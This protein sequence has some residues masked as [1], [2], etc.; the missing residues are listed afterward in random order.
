MR[1]VLIVA[2]FA[3]TPVV[4]REAPEW[5]YCDFGVDPK[6]GLMASKRWAENGMERGIAGSLYSGNRFAWLP[7]PKLAP[8]AACEAALASPDLAGN[9]MRRVSLLQARAAHHV[10]AG[11]AKAALADLDAAEAALPATL[12]PRERARS[13]TLSLA[14]LRA[15]ALIKAGDNPAAVRAV[16]QAADARPWSGHVQTLAARILSVT[17]GSEAASLRIAERRL[18]LDAGRREDLA[19]ARQAGGQF[20]AALADWRQVKPPVT[21]PTTVVVPMRGVFM[22]GQPGFPITMIDPARVGTAAL[23]AA[24]AGDAATARAW[25]ADARAAAEAAT[26]P[27]ALVLP[28]GLTGPGFPTIDKPAQ[29]AEFARYATLVDAAILYQAGKTTEARA[30]LATFGAPS[31]SPAGAQAVQRITGQTIAAAE[32]GASVDARLLFAMLP[33][34]EGADAVAVAASDDPLR[35]FL[36]GGRPNQRKPGR[37]G[38][39]GGGNF[40]KASGFKSKPMKDGRGTTITFTGDASSNYAVEEMALLRAAE[41]AREAGRTGFVI[42]DK[43]DYTRTVTM[44][45]GGSAIGGAQPAGYQTELDVAFADT[46]SDGRLVAAQSVLAALGAFYNRAP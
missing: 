36:I 44:T 5:T 16:E 45:Y 22:N 2:L 46:D 35:G 6:A 26:P 11:D 37:N 1:H 3:V 24:F 30:A 21:G 10:S 27:P 7:E 40:F 42:L 41:L 12:E 23:A 17:P 31:A 4:A 25:L 8:L 38:Y 34:Y 18:L 15:V 29:A 28:K 9:W 32:S 20:A 13:V 39:S 43:R 14:L 33:R 19:R